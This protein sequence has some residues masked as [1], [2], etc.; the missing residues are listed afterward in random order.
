M[1]RGQGIYI[2]GLDLKIAIYLEP[3]RASSNKT[4]HSSSA[5]WYHNNI[6]RGRRATA[7][8]DDD[9]MLSLKYHEK[10]IKQ[11][12]GLLLFFSLLCIWNPE[13]KFL[14][15]WDRERK[16]GGGETQYKEIKLLK[17]TL[18]CLC[19]GG[20]VP[21]ADAR[22]EKERERAGMIFLFFLRQQNK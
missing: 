8:D 12:G 15:E 19:L 16:A 17:N 9:E 11:A 22:I 21:M 6:K 13:M 20:V 10:K 1:I 7:G 3:H 18:I 4:H 5:V 14:R 2:E